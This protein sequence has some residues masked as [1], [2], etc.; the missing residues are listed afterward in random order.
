MIRDEAGGDGLEMDQAEVTMRSETHFSRW[1]S[2]TSS[3]S[4]YSYF[5]RIGDS[6]CIQN[7]LWQLTHQISEVS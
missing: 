6:C 3:P 4:W 5:M 2:I 7:L 1:T